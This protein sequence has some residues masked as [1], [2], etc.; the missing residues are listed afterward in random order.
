LFI[1]LAHAR[2][3]G[4]LCGI[5]LNEV[6]GF[7]IEN[8]SLTEMEQVLDKDVCSL[9]TGTLATV[10]DDLVS[11]LPYAVRS[12]YENICI[13]ILPYLITLPATPFIV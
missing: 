6:E 8:I 3:P 11:R 10:C 12:P 9:L 7:L 1:C 13:I 2:P 4:A 5:A